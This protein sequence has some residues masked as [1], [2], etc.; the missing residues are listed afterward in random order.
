MTLRHFKIFVTVCDTMNM[1]AAAEK[2]FISQSAVSQAIS[3]LE[4]HYGAR[5]FER[6][7]RK[8][9]LTQAGERLSGYARHILRMNSEIES[10]MKTLHQNG[11]IRIGASVTVGAHV[12][13]GLVS[14]FQQK[15][16]LT[17]VEATENNTAKIVSLILQD[18]IDLGLVEGE[19]DS[20]DVLRRPFM[21]DELAVIC[22]PRHRFAALSAIEPEDLE[23]ED[24][25]VREQGSGTRRTFEARMAEHHLSY[26]TAWT[27]TNADTIKNA[28]AAG[29]GVSVIS[30]RAVAREV[31]AGL[32]CIRR[33]KGIEFRR[34]F[35]L[36]RHK[37][38]YLTD[39]MKHF[40]ECLP[41]LPAGT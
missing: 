40:M 19:V 15:Y 12:L 10:D 11:T 33:V 3:E 41:S 37:N 7:S 31:E 24:F 18:K 2:L 5:L 14:E 9:F 32:L 25:I 26:R 23:R 34:K 22:A 6:L 21:K 27:C 30:E 29:L 38:K 35:Q 1:T 36:I 4:K 16:P 28:V 17:K 39:A 20:P 13:P 8:L